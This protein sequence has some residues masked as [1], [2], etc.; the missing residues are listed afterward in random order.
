[1][2]CPLFLSRNRGCGSWGGG[3]SE[4]SNR[5]D[6]ALSY[7]PTQP[8]ATNAPT[9][10]PSWR[11]R[12]SPLTTPVAARDEPKLAPIDGFTEQFPPPEWACSTARCRPA[13][14]HGSVTR[15]KRNKAGFN[16]PA[17]DPHLSHRALR[18]AFLR[19]L[20][21]PATPHE[22]TLRH[23]RRGAAT[24]A[25]CIDMNNQ[26]AYDFCVSTEWRLPAVQVGG[27]RWR[28]SA[29]RLACLIFAGR[30]RVFSTLRGERGG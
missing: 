28:A 21:A 10:P 23:L 14:R 25:K 9:A 5:H 18:R 15:H 11:S 19:H 24:M 13:R 6:L 22:P 7:E 2:V 30:W 20:Q 29:G 17:P 4:A 26:I 8:M 16:P 3:R 1:V 12:G 27:R